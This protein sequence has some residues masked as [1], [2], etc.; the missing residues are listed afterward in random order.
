MKMQPDIFQEAQQRVRTKAKFYKHLFA[1]MV[2]NGFFFLMALFQG[3]PFAPL[4]VTACWGV[5]LAFHYLK[6]FGIPGSGVLSRAWEDQEY[7]KELDRL[8][9][10]QQPGKTS[11]EELELKEMMKNYRDSDLV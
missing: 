11:G 7:K 3:A 8:E 10:R 4:I 2:I 1:F 9:K 6:V 5:G